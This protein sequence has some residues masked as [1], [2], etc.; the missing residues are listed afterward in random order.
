LA[1]TEDSRR[2]LLE[3]IE[4]DVK[5]LAPPI[6]DIFDAHRLD[7]ALQRQEVAAVDLRNLI[8]ALVTAA[9]EVRTDDVS[10]TLAFE[11]GGAV[12]FKIPGH[13]SRLGQVV[14]NLID[15][16]R[17]FSPHGSTVRVICR[18]L[19]NEIEIIVDDDGPGIRPEALDKIFERFYTDRPHQGFG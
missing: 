4:H 7:A 19:K 14:S 17:S 15:N 3:V 5:R 10:V 18:R 8:D 2:R 13:D 9:N 1:K 12:D 16:A 11:G 6:S